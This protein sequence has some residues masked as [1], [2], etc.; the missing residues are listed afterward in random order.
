MTAPPLQSPAPRRRNCLQVSVSLPA[1]SVC[2]ETR[3]LQCPA[4][5]PREFEQR[6]AVESLRVNDPVERLFRVAREVLIELDIAPPRLAV[7][8]GERRREIG[9][10]QALRADE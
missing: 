7:A 2:C 10:R 3:R 8:R 4:L 5:Q 1:P 6:S 9:K